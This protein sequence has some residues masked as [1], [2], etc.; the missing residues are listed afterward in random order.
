MPLLLLALGRL[1][2]EHIVFTYV[3][4]FYGLK[5]AKVIADSDVFILKR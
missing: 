3:A 1:L 2:V 4:V 5:F